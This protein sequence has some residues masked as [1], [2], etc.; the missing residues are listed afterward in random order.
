LMP[1]SQ[2]KNYY[3]LSYAFPLI[4]LVVDDIIIH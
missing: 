3:F 1:F 4:W 2:K